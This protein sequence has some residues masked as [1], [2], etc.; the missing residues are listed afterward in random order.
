MHSNTHERQ[1]FEHAGFFEEVMDA[2]T[3]KCLGTRRVAG[4]ENRPCGYHG[5]REETA[6][7][8]LSLQRGHKTIV[9]P[10]SKDKPL[11]IRTTQQII[12]GR[13]LVNIH[14]E[15]RF[16]AVSTRNLRKHL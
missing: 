13:M 12:C 9:V 4:D 11:L 7:A 6:T 8:P 1:L 5:Q 14:S 2:R 10:A 3:G 16:A 15:D